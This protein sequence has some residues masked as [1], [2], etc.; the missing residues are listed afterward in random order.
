MVCALVAAGDLEYRSRSVN[1]AIEGNIDAVI[2][3][4]VGIYLAVGFVL[5]LGAQ[6][7]RGRAL[8]APL[9]AMWSLIAVL[10]VSAL[11]APSPV[12][13]SVRALQLVIVAALVT[14][15]ARRADAK[16]F[17]AIAHAY[18]L[19]ITAFVGIGLVWRVAPNEQ[20]A[21]RFNWAATH[22]VTASS[23]LLV[24]VLILLSWTRRDAGPRFLSPRWVKALFVVHLTALLATQTRGAIFGA[25]AGA[26]VWAILAVRRR[27]DLAILAALGVPALVVLGRGS[28]ESFLLRGESTEQLRSL[29]SRTD[30]WSEAV[31]LVSDAPLHGRGYFSARELFL[32]SI[33][34]G[35]AH[36]AYIEV[37][38]SAGL[39][40]IAVL[41][42]VLI[43]T[44][45]LLRRLGRD[46]Q[47]ALVG[48][49]FAGLA[50]NGLTT[51]YWAQGGT[52]SNVW[53]LLVLG[54]VAAMW[55]VR[56]P[57]STPT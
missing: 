46:P 38:V 47:R 11:W 15:L 5:L 18:V 48:A 1:A 4:E 42:F 8:P 41:G 28:F 34:L 10:S 43:R 36:N 21:G 24:S 51:Q 9:G 3:L 16:D 20:V 30:L 52:G 35:G 45:G 13:G 32:E 53:F 55:R 23:L 27:R 26:S 12:L 2:L 14:T 37:L 54:W 40:G 29:N 56:A 39:V 33:G 7:P 57:T 6:L 19:L 50:A 49:L 22:P 17:A 44:T 31:D 25:V